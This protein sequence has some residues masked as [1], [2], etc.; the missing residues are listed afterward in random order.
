MRSLV[1]LDIEATGC[2]TATDAIVSIGIVDCIPG[3]ETVRF[4]RTF[5]PW[6]PIP[7]EVAKIIGIDDAKVAD[8]EPFSA[9]AQGIFEIL[10]D[11][12]LIGFNINGFD[13]PILFEEFYRCGIEWDLSKR[14]VLDVGTCW[15][16]LEERTLEAAVKK[17][18]G[19][20]HTGAHGAVADATATWHVYN[21]MRNVFPQLNKMSITELADF[22]K[23]DDRKNQLTLDGKII[24]GPDGD[25]VFNFGKPKG[26]KVKDDL[27]FA[28][29]I[30]GKDFPANT[31]MWI[32][33]YI[34]E[35]I[36]SS[37]DQGRGLW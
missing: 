21:N 17:F 8:L 37:P 33:R 23:F 3:Q 19:R 34:E 20:E 15:K 27:G 1:S 26:V 14:L 30:L 24:K 18:L 9:Y 10:S 25:P 31:K 22:S 5:K 2:N 12:D 4:E 13:I 6:K 7:P 28:Q 35:L 32:Q 36:A 16:K 29:W 11:K